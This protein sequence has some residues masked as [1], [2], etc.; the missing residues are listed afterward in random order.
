MPEQPTLNQLTDLVVEA[1][2]FGVTKGVLDDIETKTII[3]KYLLPHAIINLQDSLENARK[4]SEYGI[5]GSE[6][7]FAAGNIGLAA[8]GLCLAGISTQN[9]FETKNPVAKVCYAA[10]IVCSSTAMLTG[11]I[12][13]FNNVCGIS[14][15]AMCGDAFGS[16]F[17]FLGNRAKNLGNYAEGKSKIKQLNPFRNRGF[18][19]KPG[20]L[21]G[22]KGMGF[23]TPGCSNTSL[24]EIQQIIT[25]IPY[26]EIIIIGSTIFTIYT[27]GKFIIA[28]SRK[29]ASKF[30]P[31]I[32][33][34]FSP[35]I[36]SSKLIQNQAVFLINILAYKRA[37]NRI[38]IF[39]LS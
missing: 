19:R 18:K 1:L 34:K 8:G 20:S 9:Y 12:T 33:S 23:I 31:K 28:I 37:V 24:Q 29:L 16:T 39:A 36:D 6:T 13:A 11:G 25:N 32:D 30:S 38:Y 22:Y 14:R 10:S 26:Q 5:R 27:Y 2:G 17:L 3:E 15:L 4:I 21:T 35:K 7:A